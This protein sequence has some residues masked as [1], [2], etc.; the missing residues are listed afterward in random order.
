MIRKMIRDKLDSYLTPGYL[1]VRTERSHFIT[2][3]LE[4]TWKKDLIKENEM[5][6][7]DE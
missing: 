3:Q 2:K 7:L 6:V 5:R 1:K 4:C